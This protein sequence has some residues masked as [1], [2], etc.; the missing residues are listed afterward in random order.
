MNYGQGDLPFFTQSPRTSSPGLCQK[1]HGDGRLVILPSKDAFPVPLCGCVSQ[2]RCLPRLQTEGTWAPID[3]LRLLKG[4]VCE[5][6]CLRLPVAWCLW[7]LERS[8]Q[9]VEGG[10]GSGIPAVTILFAVTQLR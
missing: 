1:P 5:W 9:C 2:I 6:Q 7:Q 8:W 4:H 10:A 3:V